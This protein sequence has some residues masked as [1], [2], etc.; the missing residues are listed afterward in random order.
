MKLSRTLLMA[1]LLAVMAQ[2]ASCR[3]ELCFNHYP[4]ISVALAWEQE[5]ERD[6]GMD[7]R[8]VW[9]SDH[10]GFQYDALCPGT[11][12]WTNLIKFSPD[13]SRS[14]SF[15]HTN[16]GDVMLE[17]EQGHSLL[18][19]NGDT[20]YVVVSDIAYPTSARASA[21]GRSRASLSYVAGMHP[22]ARTTSPPDVLY[23]SYVEDIPGVKMHEKVPLDVNMKPLVYTY[24]IRY[25]F[26]YGKDHV[27]LARGAL[28]G[29]AESVYLIDGHTSD[30]SSI[31][32]YDCQ[33]TDYGCEAQVCSFGVPGFSDDNY[34]KRTATASDNPYTLNL[35]V[36]LTNGKDLEFNF[37]ISDQIAR[38]PRGGVIKVGGIRIEDAQNTGGT[39][40]DV[41]LNGWGNK[42]D[43]ILPFI[44]P[45]RSGQ[46]N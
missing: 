36:R 5:W 41:N 19:Y 44:L 21:T 45:V 32:L 1:L 23:A 4:S 24:L 27:A 7:H 16:S 30:E 13:G 12:E 31:I 34:A 25:E 14:E 26:E 17:E 20:E 39:G 2:M 38:Q 11:P 15:L 40:F 18:L 22:N 6:Y 46:K 29:M 37:D 43:I 28:G 42:E 8:N 3:D 35:E 9:D 33:I 10:Y